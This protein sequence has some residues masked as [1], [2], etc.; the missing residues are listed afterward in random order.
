MTPAASSLRWSVSIGILS[1][2]LQPNENAVNHPDLFDACQLVSRYDWLENK[3]ILLRACGESHGLNQ[4]GQIPRTGK[5]VL[6][7]TLHAEW[8]VFRTRSKCAEF[9]SR[10][11]T[12]RA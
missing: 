6:W 10:R 9:D 12:D 8:N 4:I 5:E 11:D 2:S 3:T 7:N 1:Q